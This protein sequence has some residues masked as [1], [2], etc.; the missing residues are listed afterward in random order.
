MPVAASHFVASVLGR[1]NLLNLWRANEVG[2]YLPSLHR[3]RSDDR[4]RITTLEPVDWARVDYVDMHSHPRV[5]KNL[6]VWV[7]RHL[8][9]GRE[10][11]LRHDEVFA[12]YVYEA[13]EVK[14]D[15]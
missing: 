12:R 4:L 6:K 13:W 1:R 10:V 8:D 9:A 11:T 5:Q 3:V 2:R 14:S 15:S 7:Q